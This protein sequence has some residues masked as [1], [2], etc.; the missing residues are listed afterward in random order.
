MVTK[1]EIIAAR[2]AA[3]IGTLE[4]KFTMQALDGILKIIYGMKGLTVADGM[5][6]EVDAIIGPIHDKLRTRYQFFTLGEVSIALEAGVCG[7]WNT[8]KRICIASILS[9]LAAYQKY[10]IRQ[11]A[12]QEIN[13]GVHRK[14]APASALLPAA[15]VA[16]MNEDAC[17]RGIKAAWAAFKEKGDMDII[18]DGYAANLCDYLI[19]RGKLKARDETVR[20]AWERSRR[21]VIRNGGI[22]EAFNDRMDYAAKRELLTM[23]F[24]SLK[25]RNVELQI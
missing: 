15:D 8:D 21:R 9:W 18:F 25:Q 13:K 19:N 4:P 16:R 22:A 2:S 17:I 3:P 7:E 24:G 20:E 12:I 11:E 6:K 23:Y 10:D 14:I 1:Q 5:Q